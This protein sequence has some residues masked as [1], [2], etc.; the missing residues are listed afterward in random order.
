MELGKS[1]RRRGMEEAAALI[2]ENI[3]AMVGGVNES[4]RTVKRVK[5]RDQSM[6]HPVSTAY[7]IVIGIDKPLTVCLIC[8]R[9]FVGQKICLGTRIAVLI[10]EV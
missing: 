10:I 4:T 3:F 9:R 8:F 5:T 6:K 2:I 7:R 1:G